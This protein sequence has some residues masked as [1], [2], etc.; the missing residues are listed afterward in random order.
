M[1]YLRL[2]WIGHR[3]SA[4]AGVTVA[5]DLDLRT[6]HDIAHD[7]QHRLLH[8]IPRLTAATIHVSPESAPNLDP[9]QGVEHHHPLL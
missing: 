9:H 1:E 3:I 5:P 8:E 6:A 2:R 4:E 7:A